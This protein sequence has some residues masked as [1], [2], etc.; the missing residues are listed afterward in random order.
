MKTIRP[1]ST[2]ALATLS[3]A[4]AARAQETPEPPK[5]PEPP[6]ELKE[7]L[8]EPAVPGIE[9]PMREHGEQRMERRIQER[10]RGKVTLPDRPALKERRVQ[11]RE[12]EQRAENWPLQQFERSAQEIQ[13]PPRWLIGVAVEPIEPFVRAHLGLEEDAGA[14][15]SRV[16]E[17]TPAAQAGIQVDDI[18]ISAD[19]S[20][21]TTL[22]GLRDAVEKAGKE[23][24]PLALE[25]IHRGERKT[26]SVSPKGPKPP[27]E[28]TATP[29]TP[30]QPE[31]PFVEI[32]RRLDRQEKAINELRAQLRKL[33]K[34]VNKDE[35]DGE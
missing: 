18:I 31:R 30:Q 7:H 25:I 12:L 9:R 22:E 20:K 35:K 1:I 16:E 27:E 8:E 2:V 24:K 13:V 19:G 23:G 14:R 33:R 34:Q 28:P 15:V 6:I 21:V 10:A 29:Q 4:F 17:E 11:L 3:L 26:L 5:A 32:Q